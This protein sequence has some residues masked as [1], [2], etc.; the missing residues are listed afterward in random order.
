MQM[1][2]MRKNPFQMLTEFREFAKSMTPEEA[3]KRVRE[4]GAERTD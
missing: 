3:E 4:L 2:G 1:F